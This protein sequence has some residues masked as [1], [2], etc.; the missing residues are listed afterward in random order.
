MRS[1]LPLLNAGLPVQRA[2]APARTPKIKGGDI[3]IDPIV[4]DC[5][6]SQIIFWPMQ[7]GPLGHAAVKAYRG[8]KPG[9]RTDSIRIA[10]HA[11]ACD[12]DG[13]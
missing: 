11:E 1:R 8:V 2:I 12:R 3:R 9:I 7:Y 6:R 4:L 5:E 10:H 13:P